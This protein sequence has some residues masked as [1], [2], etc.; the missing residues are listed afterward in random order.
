MI[1]CSPS[2]SPPDLPPPPLIRWHEELFP[3]CPAIC[4]STD[5]AGIANARR[6]KASQPIAP[7]GRESSPLTFHHT[8]ATP[9][10][11][12]D[13]IDRHPRRYDRQTPFSACHLGAYRITPYYIAMQVGHVNRETSSCNNDKTPSERVGGVV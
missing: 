13:V 10:N 11:D 2:L 7:D 4:S 12:N 9:R 3:R 8:H 5:A 1:N 6:G